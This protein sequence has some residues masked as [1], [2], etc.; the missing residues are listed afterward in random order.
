MDNPELNKLPDLTGLPKL[1]ILSISNTALPAD[2]RA[3][4]LRE[5]LAY[6]RTHAPA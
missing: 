6:V 5:R 4:E 3:M 2:L 1:R